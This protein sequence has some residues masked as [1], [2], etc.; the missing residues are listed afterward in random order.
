[1]SRHGSH[2]SSPEKS[3][4]LGSRVLQRVSCT[5]G[6]LGVDDDRIARGDHL[7]DRGEVP[8][9]A[10]DRVGH[11]AKKH[12]EAGAD[13]RGRG[14]EG[15]RRRGR[16]E[17]DDEEAQEQTEPEAAEGPGNGG[18]TVAESPDDPFDRFEVAADDRQL[19]DREVRVGKNINRLLG[20]GI[21]LVRNDH[22]ATR[23][24]YE[25][26]LRAGRKRLLA[27]HVLIIPWLP[28]FKV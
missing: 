10:A 3:G 4:L 24:R 26:A 17:D 25:G 2:A 23:D 22:L 14:D 11:D 27:T 28:E 18:P 1:M 9:P 15:Q 20:L 7:H 13:E 16:R 19:I 21:G 6:E 12:A 5:I 8:A